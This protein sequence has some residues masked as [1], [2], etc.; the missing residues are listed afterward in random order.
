MTVTSVL[1]Q[2]TTHEPAGNNVKK[3]K[4]IVYQMST[5]ILI[6]HFG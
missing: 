1:A 5:P 6:Q 4:K 2:L 3:D